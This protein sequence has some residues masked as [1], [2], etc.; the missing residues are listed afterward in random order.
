MAGAEPPVTPDPRKWTAIAG[1][2]IVLGIFGMATGLAVAGWSPESIIGLVSGLTAVAGRMLGIPALVLVTA[3][4]IF[5]ST[6][7]SS[8]VRPSRS[9]LQS[10][11]RRW[12][13]PP[14]CRRRLASLCRAKAKQP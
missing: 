4:A 13:E 14:I 9:P 12:L 2:I 5:T 6:F 10:L 11:F 3:V 7:L 1:S 8:R